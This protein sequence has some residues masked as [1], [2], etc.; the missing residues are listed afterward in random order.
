MHS[1]IPAVWQ[2][3]GEMQKSAAFDWV[4]ERVATDRGGRPAREKRFLA[5]KLL[6]ARLTPSWATVSGAVP[7]PEAAVSWVRTAYTA[8]DGETTGFKSTAERGA[9]PR[10]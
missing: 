8:A 10:L 9:A 5:Y 6:A 7:L 3:L 1:K 2:S 4:R